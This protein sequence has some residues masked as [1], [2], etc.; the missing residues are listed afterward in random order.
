MPI[1]C[2]EGGIVLKR[3]VIAGHEMQVWSICCPWPHVSPFARYTYQLYRAWKAGFLPGPGGMD[4]QPAPLMDAI[5]MYDA[6]FN[7]AERK[8]LDALKKR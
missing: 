1:S 7:E 6:I 3:K 8:Q 5:L 2:R 4:D